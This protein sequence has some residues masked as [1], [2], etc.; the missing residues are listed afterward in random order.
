M[1]T[2]K[3]EPLIQSLTDRQGQ[4]GQHLIMVGRRTGKQSAMLQQIITRLLLGESVGFPG[5]KDPDALIAKLGIACEAELMAVTKRNGEVVE[6][7]YLL[8]YKGE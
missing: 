5:C 3:T 1:I 2:S 4:P 7:G 8:R 6:T